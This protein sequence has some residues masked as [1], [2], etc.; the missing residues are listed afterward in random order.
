MTTSDGWLSWFHWVTLYLNIAKHG[1]LSGHK[2]VMKK[3]KSSV[4]FFPGTVLLLWNI[5]SRDIIRA[6]QHVTS[7]GVSRKHL[8]FS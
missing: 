5:L 8:D 6:F 3:G 7:R 2:V 1:V 4:T